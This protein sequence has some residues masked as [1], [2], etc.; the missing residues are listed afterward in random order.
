MDVPNVLDS[1]IILV[2]PACSIGPS[3]EINGA[4][5]LIQVIHHFVGK[6][7]G[8]EGDGGTIIESIPCFIGQGFKFGNESIDFPWV[9]VRWRSFSSARS[10]APVS[11]NN[12]S[13]ALVM[14]FQ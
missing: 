5:N 6:F 8:E 2:I 14:A 13:K 7:G 9:K 11:W 10:V 12:V 3:C 1:L 4:N